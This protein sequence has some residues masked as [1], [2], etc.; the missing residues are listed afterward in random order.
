MYAPYKANR[1]H[2]TLVLHT[3][4]QQLSQVINITADLK[5]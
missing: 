3:N 2:G 5:M 4:H 1:F